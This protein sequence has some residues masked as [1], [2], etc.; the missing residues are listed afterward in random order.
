M[1]ALILAATWL[2]SLVAPKDALKVVY[3]QHGTE[4][5][6]VQPAACAG[7]QYLTV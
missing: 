1:T 5:T 2:S 4:L 3:F 7:R 6:L